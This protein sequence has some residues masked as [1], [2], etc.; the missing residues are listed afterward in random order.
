MNEYIEEE[1]EESVESKKTRKPKVVD[2][3]EDATDGDDDGY[4][5]DGTIW[6]RPVEETSAETVHIAT[7]GETYLSIAI[8]N[9]KGTSYAKEIRQKNNNKAIRSGVIINL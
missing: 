7:T 6:E 4:V 8:K 2:F 9:N 3:K 5:Q 1:L